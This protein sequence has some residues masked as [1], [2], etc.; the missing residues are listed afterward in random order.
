MVGDRNLCQANMK[1]F[2]LQID[3]MPWS[4]DDSAYN[5]LVSDKS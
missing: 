2:T 5:Q 4:P 1:I 3:V